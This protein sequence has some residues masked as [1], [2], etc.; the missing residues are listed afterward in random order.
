MYTLLRKSGLKGIMYQ[1]LPAALLSLFV[2]EAL[3]KFGS[4]TLEV[5]AF[6]ATW[7]VLDAA[8]QGV[9]DLLKTDLADE[10]A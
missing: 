6:L 10:G 3:Y 2:A 9:R 4:F 1:Q 5:A 7:F 8:I